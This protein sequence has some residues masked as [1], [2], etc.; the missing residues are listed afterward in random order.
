MSIPLPPKFE[1]DFGS[2]QVKITVDS[3]LLTWKL[4]GNGGGSYPLR[5]LSGVQYEAGGLMSWMSHLVFLASGGVN[6]QVQIP[7]SEKSRQI[8]AS[9]NSYI[10]AYHIEQ[11]SYATTVPSASLADELR[12][13]ADLRDAGV[14]TEAEFT[15]QKRRALNH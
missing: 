2:A 10:E 5:S 6:K 1:W 13:L 14:L 7:K 8:I 11:Q 4:L 12:K 3:G 9:I 15:E